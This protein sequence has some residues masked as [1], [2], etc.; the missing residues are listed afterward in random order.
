MQAV[1]SSRQLSTYMLLAHR[2]GQPCRQ[3]AGRWSSAITCRALS[4]RWATWRPKWFCALMCAPSVTQSSFPSET[5]KV[6]SQ[7]IKMLQLQCP[8]ARVAAMRGRSTGTAASRRGAV[9]RIL[10]LPP[11]A[12]GSSNGAQGD[13]KHSEKVESLHPARPDVHGSWVAPAARMLFPGWQ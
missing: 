12:S 13:G 6:S 8:S 9:R 4:S 3:L 1:R 11:Q 5:I 10:A 2:A 7:I